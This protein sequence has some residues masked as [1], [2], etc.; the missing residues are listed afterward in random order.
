MARR[1]LV[2]EDDEDIARLVR[3]QLQE[4]SCTVRTASDGAV[5]LAEAVAADWDLIILDLMLPSVDGLEICR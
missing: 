1:V 5:G 3:L 2:V 4:L